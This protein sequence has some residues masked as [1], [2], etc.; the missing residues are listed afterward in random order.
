[1]IYLFEQFM[2]TSRNRIISILPEVLVL[3]T[4]LLLTFG[5][6][7]NDPHSNL[8]IINSD[9]R[10]YYAYLPATFI[11]KDFSFQKTYKAEQEAS[12]V[13]LKQLYIL[14][15]DE[16]KTF[17]KYYPGVALMQSPAFGLA[18]LVELSRGSPITGYSPTFF[19]FFQLFSLLF[20]VLG[21][22]FLRKYLGLV[23]ENK[24][25]VLITSVLIFFGTTLFYQIVF[26]P[27]LS[28][29]YS[30]FL[31]SAFSYLI[32]SYEKSP[33]IKKSILSGIVFG[34][35]LLVRPVN[36]LVIFAIP[37]ILGSFEKLKS[38]FQSLFHWRN[39]HLISVLISV[40]I[41]LIPLFWLNYQQIGQIW[42][43]SY[44]SEGFN[45]SN[46]HFF[47]LLIGFRTGFFVHTPLAF[48]A[49]IGLF[50]L[51]RKNKLQAI[52]GLFYFF[53]ITYILSSW[54]SWDF[55]GFFGNRMYTEQ[56][57]FLAL[58]LAYFINGFNRK[59][60]PISIGIACTILIFL[61]L[62]QLENG[63]IQHRFTA[64]T[65][66]KSLTSIDKEDAG[67]FA[68]P[69]EVSPYGAMTN[70]WEF[71]ASEATPIEF[72]PEKQ[73]GC[74]N[75]FT[76]PEDKLF[77]SYYFQFEIDKK[78]SEDNDF[79]DVVLVMDAVDTV[80]QD[81]LYAT[82][83]LYEYY[84][85]GSK[86]IDYQLIQQAYFANGWNNYDVFKCYIYNKGG[87]SFSIHNYKLTIQEFTP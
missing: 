24:K 49:F 34:L 18:Y 27:S 29:H 69:R 70:E 14:T 75:S 59:W 55:G 6:Q 68:F 28:H 86:S 43:W 72:T 7:R 42:N 79:R 8:K 11:Q 5:V 74:T 57:V 65:Y 16:G 41:I 66:F 52:V 53:G 71:Q 19:L 56:L 58:P 61:R 32:V 35:I 21:F 83:P 81:R 87:K 30:F 44:K 37:L 10:G 45:F 20:G 82:V 15:N 48:F 39:F 78:L 40:I 46:P 36:L 47:E 60:I 85:E 67:K 17:N 51:F 23:I 54:W 62:Y 13:D 64:E 22:Y 31:F 63:I 3:L 1:M 12:G 26:T 73:F 77:K 80:T 84:L 50:F 76:L 9:G 38:F 4:L 33:S 2:S 25:I